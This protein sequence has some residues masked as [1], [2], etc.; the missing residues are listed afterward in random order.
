MGRKLKTMYWQGEK[1]SKG[2]LG[3][4][5]WGKDSKPVNKR[6]KEEGK[7]LGARGRISGKR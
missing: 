5:N 4:Q 2:K 7:K 3:G 6:E 1:K